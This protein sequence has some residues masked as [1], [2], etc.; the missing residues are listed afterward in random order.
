MNVNVGNA[1][2]W[3][4]LECICNDEGAERSKRIWKSL[5]ARLD[6][7]EHRVLPQP[8]ICAPSHMGRLEG[9]ASAEA[10]LERL[11]TAEALT[12]QLAR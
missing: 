6:A 4:H 3:P 2:C 5:F 7:A 11:A 10:A 8:A 9:V 1:T 12:A